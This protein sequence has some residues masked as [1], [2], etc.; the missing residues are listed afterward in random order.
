M[1]GTLDGSKTRKLVLEEDYLDAMNRVAQTT[2]LI[3]KKQLA[4]FKITLFN[5]TTRKE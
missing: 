2:D 5:T 1:T 4:K 3:E